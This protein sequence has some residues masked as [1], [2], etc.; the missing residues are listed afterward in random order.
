M[1]W[2]T[3][4]G[5]RL[6]LLRDVRDTMFSIQ[7]LV[8]DPHESIEKEI[9][10]YSASSDPFI[11][12]WQ[13]NSSNGKQILLDEWTNISSVRTSN[14]G[15]GGTIYQHETGIYQIIFQDDGDEIN[16]W[17]AS[18]DGT[19]KCLSRN[20]NWCAVE[21]YEHKDYVRAVS[22]TEKLVITAGRDENIKIWDRTSGELLHVYEGH[23]DEV[24]GLVLIDNQ[25]KLV[26]VSIDGTVRCWGLE[27]HELERAIYRNE[28][29]DSVD[30]REPEELGPQVQLTSDEEAQLK[31]LMELDDL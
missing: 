22:V 13:L 19:A 8:I 25:R 15:I 11:R 2:D 26:S 18:A 28:N 10:L 1:V 24:T 29:G 20:K 31:E 17:T 9:I 30:T 7:D 5:V 23:F 3:S 12:K 4:T 27:A 21:I 6:Y 16:I 14:P